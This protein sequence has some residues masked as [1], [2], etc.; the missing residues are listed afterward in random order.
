MRTDES[1]DQASQQRS[2]SSAKG[3]FT[4][5][6]IVVSA[7]IF[8]IAGLS[9]LAR[10]VGILDATQRQYFIQPAILLLGLAGFA[11]I[12]IAQ[13]L[14]RKLRKRTSRTQ[15]ASIPDLTTPAPLQEL[16]RLRSAQVETESIV[17]KVVFGCLG[18]ALIV[19]ISTLIGISLLMFNVGFVVAYWVAAL[20]VFGIVAL[21][22]WQFK[23]HDARKGRKPRYFY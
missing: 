16:P 3:R 14:F 1:S 12:P 23:N 5:G 22:R 13:R 19:I 2:L 9:L 15:A 10:S 17:Q 20:A 11:C 6:F 8:G 7:I 4:F 18:T 21:W